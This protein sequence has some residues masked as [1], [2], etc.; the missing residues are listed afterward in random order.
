VSAEERAR[1]SRTRRTAS[2]TRSA[3]MRFVVERRSSRESG[4]KDQR[5]YWVDVRYLSSSDILSIWLWG[6]SCSRN[7]FWAVEVGSLKELNILRSAVGS[8]GSLILEV[9]T[10]AYK[11]RAP[12]YQCKGKPEALS[13]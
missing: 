7:H 13:L 6:V 5:R 11:K 9:S 10:S 4:V 3:A 2:R 8:K 12:F 1:A